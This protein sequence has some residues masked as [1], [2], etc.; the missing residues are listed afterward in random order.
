MKYIKNYLRSVSIF[1]IAI[2]FFFSGCENKEEGEFTNI[3]EVLS[4]DS[5]LSTLVA[6]LQYGKVGSILEAYGPI[7]VFAPTNDAFDDLGAIPG[8]VVL[9]QVL[10]HHVVS[11]ANLASSA[12]NDGDNVATTLEGDD[13]T[14]TVIGNPVIVTDG[15]GNEAV[16]IATDV[17]AG[18]GVIHVLDAVLLPDTTN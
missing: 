9:T 2:L 17:Q 1:G 11:E 15:S 7:T 8:E 16:I 5:S 18:N 14:V 13:I 12:L 6:A 10:L 4:S 3:V